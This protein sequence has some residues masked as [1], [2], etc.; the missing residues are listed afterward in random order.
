LVPF[1]AGEMFTLVDNVEQYP[2]FLPWCKS[3]VVLSRTDQVVEATLELQRGAVSKKFTTRNTCREFESIELAL[4]DGPFRQLAGGWTFKGLGDA[5][6]KVSLDLEFEFES[7]L[8]DMIFGSFF[9]DTCNS[10]VDSF[11]QRAESVYGSS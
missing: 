2:A 4:I 11:T 9:E 8:V 1:A 6:S 3:A 5:G 7:T 10:L